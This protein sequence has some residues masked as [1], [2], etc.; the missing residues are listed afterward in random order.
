MGSRE[1]QSAASAE[2]PPLRVSGT[3]YAEDEFAYKRAA[4]VVYELTFQDAFQRVCNS[5]ERCATHAFSAMK[6]K[7]PQPPTRGLVSTRIYTQC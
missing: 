3:A 5:P 2:F 7:R 1:H 6:N 4:D